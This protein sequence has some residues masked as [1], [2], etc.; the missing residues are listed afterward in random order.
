MV[1]SCNA[2]GLLESSK[3]SYAGVCSLRKPAIATQVMIQ[4]P[5]L[6]S[7]LQKAADVQEGVNICSSAS[8]L[9][10]SEGHTFLTPPNSSSSTLSSR[11]YSPAGAM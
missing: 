5:A 7:C 1:Y 2:N 8:D 6:C 3:I 10:L 11:L 4:M 9:A